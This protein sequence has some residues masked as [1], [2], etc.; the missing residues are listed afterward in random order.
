EFG[1][2]L[3]GSVKLYYGS[4]E[5]KVK[6]GECFYFKATKSHYLTNEGKCD[7]EIL[8]ISSPPNF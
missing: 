4:D 5:Y 3:R 6:K 8:W 1:F 7:T 2:V